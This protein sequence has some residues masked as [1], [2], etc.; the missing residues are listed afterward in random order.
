MDM[1]KMGKVRQGSV[2]IFE[3]NILHHNALKT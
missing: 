3:K 2:E 1:P